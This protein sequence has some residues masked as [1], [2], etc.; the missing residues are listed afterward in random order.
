M[1]DCPYCGNV[2]YSFEEDQQNGTVVIQVVCPTCYGVQS[3]VLLEVHPLFR[4][5]SS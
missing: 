1:T 4:Q 2:L 5:D 3:T